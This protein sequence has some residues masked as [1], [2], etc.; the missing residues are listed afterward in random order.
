MLFGIVLPSARFA[1]AR[2]R[3]AA[4]RQQ[5][6]RAMAAQR[7]RCRTACPPFSRR[8]RQ[9][10]SKTAPVAPAGLRVRNGKEKSGS[11]VLTKARLIRLLSGNAACQWVCRGAPSLPSR[12]Q[13][14][15]CCAEKGTAPAR[16]QHAVHSQ[17]GNCRER[18]GRHAALVG[19]A[20]W[21]CATATAAPGSHPRRRRGGAWLERAAGGWHLHAGS[22]G[23]RDSAQVCGIHA[24]Q[25]S[26]PKTTAQPATYV[27]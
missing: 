22:G 5:G 9:T 24:T 7:W 6:A 17:A 4:G 16:R 2:G 23:G 21:A 15:G 14:G 1:C 18:S 3:T 13:S 27:P 12:E 25:H 8:A 10:R 11:S 20:A 19:P 26:L